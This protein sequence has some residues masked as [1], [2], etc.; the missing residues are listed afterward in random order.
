MSKLPAHPAK[1]DYRNLRKAAQF[2]VALPAT[3]R[4][5]ALL[6]DELQPRALLRQFPRIANV[7]AR[8]W[9]DQK[10][11]EKF[12]NELLTDRRGNRQ[13]FPPEVHIELL[14]IR[15]YI[16]GRTPGGDAGQRRTTRR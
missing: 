9:D 15:D 1:G 2:N 14:N 4:W 7:I 5:L 11:L 8:T 10:S 6:P 12:L 13:G 3:N 16:E